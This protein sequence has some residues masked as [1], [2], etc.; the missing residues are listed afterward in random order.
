[1]MEKKKNIA[2]ALGSGGARGLA[3]IGVIEELLE[4]GYTISS[5]SGTSIGAVVAGVYVLGGLN[6]YKE[7]MLSLSKMEVFQLMDFTLSSNGLMKGD[8]VFSRMKTLIPDR[9]IEDLAIP[10][11]A[12]ATDIVGRQEVIYDKGSVYKAMRA[13][14]SIPTV[15]VPVSS[16]SMKIVDGGLL[17]PVPMRQIQRFEGDVLFGVNL[18]GPIDESLYDHED[19]KE[20]NTVTNKFFPALEHSPYANFIS[21]IQESLPKF[22]R[23]SLSYSNILNTTIEIMLDKIAELELEKYNPEIVVNLPRNLSS[24]FEFYNAATIIDAGRMAARNALDAYENQ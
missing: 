7:W 13:S 1:M 16:D 3:H 10:F 20:H 24:T 19:E 4:R 9:N 5:I 15:F 2:L 21:K 22:H 23:D 14:V 6:A 17:N 18:Y 12:L 8:K 11:V